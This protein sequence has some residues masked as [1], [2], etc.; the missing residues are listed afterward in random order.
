MQAK[1]I[2]IFRLDAAIVVAT[3]VLHGTLTLLNRMV[4][5]R[6]EV[7]QGNGWISLSACTRLLYTLLS[8]GAGTSGLSVTAGSPAIGTTILPMRCAPWPGARTLPG[9]L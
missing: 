4:C 9:E 8:C 1:S 3:L 6:P 5:G 2:S 7:L